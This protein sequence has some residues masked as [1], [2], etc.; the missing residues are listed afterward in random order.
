MIAPLA[1]GLLASVGCVNTD[2]TIFTEVTPKDFS[3]NVEQQAL[4]AQITGGFT[5]EL[6]L[7]ARAAGSSEV[8]IQQFEIISKDENTIIVDSLPLAVDGQELPIVVEPDT[9]ADVV[10]KIDYGSQLEENSVG[11]NLCNFGLVRFRGSVTE[12]L[13]GGTVPVLTEPLQVTG[14]AP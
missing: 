12:S 4:G 3:V 14:C 5:L 1:A 2:P 10:V 9:D 6:H 11:D 7:G 8:D 13:K